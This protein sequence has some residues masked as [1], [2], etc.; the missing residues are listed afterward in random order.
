MLRVNA[1]NLRQLD[2]KAVDFHLIVEAADKHIVPSL[3]SSYE[4]S[5][6]VDHPRAEWILDKPLTSEMRG[7]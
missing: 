7:I 6:S 4:I 1:L 5:G 2:A 3:E